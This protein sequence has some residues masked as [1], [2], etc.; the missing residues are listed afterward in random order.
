V[1]GQALVFRAGPHLCGIGVEHVT[2]VLRPLPVRPLA[3]APAFVC[4]VSVLRGV[5]VPV[6][7]VRSL[8]V[9][10]RQAS[11]GPAARLVGLRAVPRPAALTVDEVLGVRDLPLDLL[12]EVSSVFDQAAHGT[13]AA[14]GA[15]DDQPLL[16]LE[17]TRVVPDS[18]WAVLE[19]A[20][21]GR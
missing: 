17:A 16:F 12:Y 9:G 4:G 11:G 15:V 10:Q 8:V 19:T 14:L 18:V 7:S 21:A 3:G 1:G 5:P 6:I 2:E 13:V 20:E